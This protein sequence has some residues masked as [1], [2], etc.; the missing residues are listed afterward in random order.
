MNAVS[1]ART[2]RVWDLPTRLFHWALVVLI[3][4][5]YASG[6]FNLLSMQWH[7]RLGY[8]TLALVVFRVLWGLFGSQTS[9]FT[10]FVRGPVGVW[11]YVCA[12]LEQ[13]RPF[14]VGHNPLGGWSVLAMLASLLLQALSGLFASDDIMTEGPLAEHVPDRVVKWA[15]RVHHW[16]ETLL[17]VLVVLHVVAVLLYLLLQRDNLIAPMLNGR[18]RI[19][20]LQPRLAS[21]WLALA[22]FAVSAGAVAVLVWWAG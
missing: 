21:P 18:R 1:N 14:S 13:R 15:T 5:Q 10:G 17:L 16:N 11:R 19:D 22:L 3:A 2:I 7:V 8:A 4:L 9:R 6:E 12:M 20:A